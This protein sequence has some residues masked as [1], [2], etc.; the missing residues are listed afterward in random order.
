MMRFTPHAHGLGL[1]VDSIE[2]GRVW[3]RVAHKPEL[4]G[5]PE[6]GVIAGGVIIAL[7][8]HFCGAAVMAALRAPQ[9]IA[10]LDLRIDYMRPATAGQDVLV[11]A[12]CYKVTRS[13]AFT[14]AVAYQDDVDD[15]IANA[16][17]AFMMTTSPF[18]GGPM[19]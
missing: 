13:V 1:H 10:T 11:M 12:H 18:P 5:D 16:A 9:P 3:G 7:L 2:A 19:P 8:D 15:P 4:I 6:T 14:R 17:G